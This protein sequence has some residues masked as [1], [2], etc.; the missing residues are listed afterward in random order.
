MEQL[1]KQKEELKFLKNK[2]EKKLFLIENELIKYEQEM[3]KFSEEQLVN[4]LTLSVQQKVIVDAV[5]DNILV[6]ACPGAGK[7]HTL[8]SRYVNLILKNNIKPESILLITFT[9]KAGQEM[10]HRLEDIVPNKLPFYVGSLHGLS[11]RILQKYNNINYTILDEKETKELLKQETNLIM[12]NITL[13]EDI[14][15]LIKSKICNIIEQASTTYP[16]NFKVILKKYN[17]TKHYNLVNQIYKAFSKKKKQ[18]NSIDFN[19]LMIQFC[20]FLKSTKSTEFKSAINYIF[21]DEYQDINPIQ[22]YILSIFKNKSKIMVVG[23]DAQS[24]YS[25][26]GSSIKYIC[27]FSDDFIPNGKY[28]LID[29]YRSSPAIVNFCQNIIDKNINQYDK[30]VISVQS[31]FG[32]KPSIHAFAS[33]CCD[34]SIKITSKEEQY[35]WIV[36]DIINKNK[37]GV[38]FSNMVILSRT[39]RSLANIELE[40]IANQV[41]II[42]QIGTALLDKYH[43]KDF[44]AFIIIINNPKSSIHWKRIISLHKGIGPIKANAIVE[45]C[46]NIYDKILGLSSGNE[47]LNNLVTV[48]N[49]INNINRD[50]DKA[51]IILSYLEKLWLYKNKI[52]NE[53]RSDILS[54][55]YYLRNSSLIEFINNLHLNQEI[56]TTYDNVLFLSTI[57]SAKGLEWEYVYLIDVNNYEFPNVQNAYYT[58]ELENMEEERRLFYVACSRA[59]KYLTITYHTDAKVAMSPFIRELNP[60]LYFSN[61]VIKNDLILENNIPRDVTT[62]IKNIGHVNIIKLFDN[63]KIKEKSIHCEFEIPKYI[64]K[65]KN[66]FVIGKFIDYLIPKIIQNNFPDKTKKFDLGII[67]KEDKFPKKIYHEYIDENNHWSNLLEDI[68]YIS[69]YNSEISS[70][71]LYNEFLLTNNLFYKELEIGIIKLVEQFKP[72]TIL[73]HYN[74]SFDLLKGEID[75]L[76]DDVLIEVKVT[77]NEICCIQYL[78]QVFTYGYLLSKKEIKI[79]KIILYNVESGIINII[80]TSTIDFELFY[81]NMYLINP[82]LSY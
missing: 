54:L 7:T 13:D 37:N 72:K 61:N 56:E 5:D 76:F 24:I 42:K 33:K 28:F 80:D 31:E 67:H 74:I 11:Y 16:I 27:N 75:L 52:I 82:N 19:D 3:S 23:D 26:R 69:T 2:Y 15:N 65:L 32:F 20:D 21:F 43:V 70:I 57:H 12:D 18:E 10:L 64:S 62:I 66:K 41:P 29:N 34:S 47:Q 81:K 8:I 77:S 17:L 59:K 71:E 36:Q 79:N 45:N 9:K 44:L 50:I 14:I 6:I 48:I 4:S 53:Y 35:K 51:K 58:D 73:N 1:L 49:I 22:N 46:L 63:L 78:C 30:K 25:F 39:N 40:L 60:E 38:S 68:F 55:L